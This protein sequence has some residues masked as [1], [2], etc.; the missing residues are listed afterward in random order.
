MK[1]KILWGLKLFH[2]FPLLETSVWILKQTAL[3]QREPLLRKN[4][5]TDNERPS[6]VSI[7]GTYFG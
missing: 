6:E 2:E 7:Y 5:K 1:R 3:M 4:N